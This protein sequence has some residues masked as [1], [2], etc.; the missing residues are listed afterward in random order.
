MV[1]HSKI[2]TLSPLSNFSLVY[3]SIQS[4]QKEKLILKNAGHNLFAENPEQKMIF[5]KVTTFLKKFNP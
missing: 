2:D 1:M 3:D 5:E 4:N